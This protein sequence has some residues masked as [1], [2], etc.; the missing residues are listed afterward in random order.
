M[1]ENTEEKRR[2]SWYRTKIDRE[3]LAALNQRSDLLG[4]LQT[5]G[6]LG[7]LTATGALAWWA[8]LNLA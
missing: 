8:T 7:T 6:Y 2:I 3:L 5:L 1:S 4:A